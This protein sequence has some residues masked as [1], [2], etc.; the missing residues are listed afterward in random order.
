MTFKFGDSIMNSAKFKVSD[1]GLGKIHKC[2]NLKKLIQET[3]KQNSK[4]GA[5][6]IYNLRNDD[7]VDD[8]IKVTFYNLYNQDGVKQQLKYLE[9]V[10][11]D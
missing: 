11:H 2:Y 3:D 1:E 9:P 5:R 10:L 4:F 7:D 6:K 8:M